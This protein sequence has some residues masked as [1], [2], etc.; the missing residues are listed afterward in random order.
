[1]LEQE[2]ALHEQ[3]GISIQDVQRDIDKAMSSQG[4][5]GPG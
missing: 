1:M 5:Q 3:P 4:I 2:D